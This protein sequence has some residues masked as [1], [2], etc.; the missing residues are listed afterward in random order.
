MVLL[1]EGKGVTNAHVIESFLRMAS[2]WGMPGALYLD[3]GSEYNWAEFVDDAMK[4]MGPKLI[5]GRESGVVNAKPYN[6]RAKEIEGFFG[7]F[8]RHYLVSV[9]G[10]I[11]GDRMK[12]KTSNVGKAPTPF[13]GGFDHFVALVQAHLTL[14]H[15]RPQKGRKLKG[16][17]P[18]EA[19]EKAIAAGWAKT[20]I[21]P[22][23]FVTAFSTEERRLNRQGRIE[24]KGAS[25]TC[26]GLQSCLD[27]YV[28]VLVPKYQSWDRLPIRDEKG[29]PIGLASRDVEFHP[30]D[31]VGA[32]EAG[33][34]AGRRLKSVKALARSIPTIDPVAEIIDLVPKLPK[35]PIA[36]IGA[37]IG[38]SDEARAIAG[39]LTETPKE[40]RAREQAELK[41]AHEANQEFTRR[42][43]ENKKDAS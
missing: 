17:S 23:A 10:W 39:Q 43:L 3:N 29:R 41:R 4:L 28:T 22:A 15:N 7:R 5:F 38:A 11:G 34:R 20:A 36:P 19:Y 33:A 18:F 40:R 12:S 2:E 21:D 8:E 32:R 13:P 31:P 25:W 14:Y 27:E 37:R 6:A 42:L 30:L 9:P 24:Y 1:E 16:L 35:P 26:D